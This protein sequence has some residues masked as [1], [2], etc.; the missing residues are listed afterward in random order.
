[1]KAKIQI[2]PAIIPA[3]RLTP[4]AQEGWPK[5]SLSRLKSTEIKCS[6]KLERVSRKRNEK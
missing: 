3:G 2:H 5:L 4:K 6:K 1:M